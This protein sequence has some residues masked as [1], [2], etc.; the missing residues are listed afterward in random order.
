LLHTN[1]F[2]PRHPG[3]ST[4]WVWSSA[5]SIS[6]AT[7]CGLQRCNMAILGPMHAC[8][9]NNKKYNNMAILGPM[10]AFRCHFVLVADHN[11]KHFRFVFRFVQQNSFYTIVPKHTLASYRCLAPSV[12]SCSGDPGACQWA[13]ASNASTT[14]FCRTSRCR[15]SRRNTRATACCGISAA[16]SRGRALVAAQAVY[17]QP[18]G[19]LHTMARIWPDRHLRFMCPG[20]CA[21]QFLSGLTPTMKRYLQMFSTGAATNRLACAACLIGLGRVS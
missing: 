16:T 14:I 17:M 8:K 12:A 11:T 3:D 1:R 9:Q 5:C 6:T 7:L 2:A 4:A 10:L 18:S 13:H 21:P 19:N 15:T 20:A